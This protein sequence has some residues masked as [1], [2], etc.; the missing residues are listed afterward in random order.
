MRTV[1]CIKWKS[2]SSL[3]LGGVS[4]LLFQITSSDS[5]KPQCQCVLLPY[6]I[7]LFHV[8]SFFSWLDLGFIIM[9][10]HWVGILGLQRKNA[11]PSFAS[12]GR[13]FR[14]NHTPNWTLVKQAFKDKTYWLPWTCK[15]H[16]K[17]WSPHIHCTEFNYP[18]GWC[19]KADRFLL[20]TRFYTLHN[21]RAV[22]V[23]LI[24]WSFIWLLPDWSQI[25][26]MLSILVPWI[27]A[28]EVLVWWIIEYVCKSQP[29]ECS[30][31]VEVSRS[32]DELLQS[33]FIAL[34]HGLVE[35]L[36]AQWHALDLSNYHFLEWIEREKATR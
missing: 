34:L 15:I 16:K 22:L 27:F 23:K 31:R 17:N 33:K 28:V 4:F 10:H 5:S 21:V 18:K 24:S 6:I 13:K 26:E 3:W 1:S 9:F 12:R 14:I 2:E 11:R 8:F 7:R 19:E 36:M 20:C 29:S 25:Q 35:L 30:K 32:Y